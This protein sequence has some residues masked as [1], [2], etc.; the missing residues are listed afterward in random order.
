M[1]TTKTAIAI[2]TSSETGDPNLLFHLVEG[3]FFWMLDGLMSY[4]FMTLKKK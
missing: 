2:S 1:I 4:Y 3:I